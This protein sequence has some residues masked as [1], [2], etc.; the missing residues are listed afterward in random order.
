MPSQT[1]SFYAIELQRSLDPSKSRLAIDSHIEL[2]RSHPSKSRLAI[3]SHLAIQAVLGGP[4][5]FYFA[6][7]AHRCVRRFREEGF[8]KARMVK[9]QVT[10]A[11]PESPRAQRRQKPTPNKHGALGPRANSLARGALCL[12]FAICHLPSAIAGSP[13]Q[14]S[15]AADLVRPSTLNPQPSTPPVPIPLAIVPPPDVFWFGLR[16]APVGCSYQGFLIFTNATNATALQLTLAPWTNTDL[17][18]LTNSTWTNAIIPG[19]TNSI[20]VLDWTLVGSGLTNSVLLGTNFTGTANWI[21][22]YPPPLTNLVLTVT[23]AT[24]ATNIVRSPSLSGPWILL[25]TTNYIATN[26]PGTFYFRGKGKKGN[27]ISISAHLQ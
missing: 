19:T 23:A 18:C 10:C 26:P 9:V 5:L 25:G 3:D 13:T 12:L 21:T 2:Q 15:A 22:L 8:Q 14:G 7:D 24:G 16:F 11:W 4:L 17:Q 6:A 1:E 27:T 20:D